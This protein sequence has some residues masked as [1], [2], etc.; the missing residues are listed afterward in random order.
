[1]SEITAAGV[2]IRC[3][4]GRYLL[5]RATNHKEPC[6]TIFKGIQEGTELIRNTAI[7]ETKEETGIDINSEPSLV[8]NLS[9]HSI[10]TYHINSTDKDVYVFLL[11]DKHGIIDSMELKCN[12][13]FGP[14]ND[15]PEITEFKRFSLSELK[16][17]LF[18]SQLGLI[19]VLK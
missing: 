4:D 18:P 7:R 2:I 5:G 14:N 8:Y 19:K 16:D 12:S 3:K 13:F 1:M 6:W 11:D 17:H 10:F 15:I 9:K